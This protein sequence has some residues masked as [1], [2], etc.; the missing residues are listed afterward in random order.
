MVYYRSSRHLS[1]LVTY[2]KYLIMHLEFK[3]NHQAV[4][5]QLHWGVAT[6]M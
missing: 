2:F 4:C 1:T 6:A 5:M 3:D